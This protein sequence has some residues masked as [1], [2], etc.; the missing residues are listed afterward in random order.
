MLAAHGITDTGRVRKS[1]EDALYWSTELGLFIVADGMG[2]HNAGEVASQLTV[3]TIRDY[4]V[5]GESDPDTTMPFGIDPALSI[6]ANRVA[7][8]IRLANTHVFSTSEA[9]PSYSGMGTTVCVVLIRGDRM[10]FAGVGDSRI[11]SWLN[12]SLRQLTLDD[13]WVERIRAEHPDISEDALASNPLRHVLTN[14]I[15]AKPD[16]EVRVEER[17]LADGEVLM[18]CSDGLYGPL[19]TASLT[20]LMNKTGPLETRAQA[21]LVAALDGGSRDNATVLLVEYRR[22]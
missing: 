10:T 19:D 18:L 12:G 6:E 21:M 13:S 11:Y 7:T 22:S 1:N 5:R 4:I 3:D 20:A 9:N 2:G 8:A 17:T 14:V 16:T 15:G